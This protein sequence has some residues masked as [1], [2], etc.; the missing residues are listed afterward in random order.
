MVVAFTATALRCSTG[1]PVPESPRPA[2]TISTEDRGV[3]VHEDDAIVPGYTVAQGSSGAQNSRADTDAADPKRVAAEAAAKHD[4]KVTVG[5]DE[6]SAPHRTSMPERR[7]ATKTRAGGV[8]KAAP[9]ASEAS[10][11][12]GLWRVE[13]THTTEGQLEADR[14]LFVADGRMRIWHAGKPEDGRWT[15]TKED[16]VKTGGLERVAIV[17]GEFEVEGVT[18]TLSTDPTTRVVLSPDR[19]FV[20]PA[21]LRPDPSHP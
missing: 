13:R 8:R 10:P 20:A 21:S 11:V 7:N 15:W 4:E 9:V 14:V 2:A 19:L 16:G 12:L 6:P 17:L 5:S 1:E 18:L 3:I